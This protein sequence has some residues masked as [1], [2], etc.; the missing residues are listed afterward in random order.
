MAG[1]AV[2]VDHVATLRQNRGTRYP[3]PVAAA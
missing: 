3:E 2:N 1:L